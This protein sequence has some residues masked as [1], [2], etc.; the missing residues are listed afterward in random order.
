MGTVSYT[1]KNV[2][3][4]ILRNTPAAI[5]LLALGIG[6]GA[7]DERIMTTRECEGMAK[8]ISEIDSEAEIARLHTS[9]IVRKRSQKCIQEHGI[10]IFN[11][12]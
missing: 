10:S 7:I 2:G 9:E 1:L 12:S 3:R 6:L 5:A 11:N 4:A 8:I